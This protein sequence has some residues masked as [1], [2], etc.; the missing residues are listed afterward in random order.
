MIEN[1]FRY[2]LAIDFSCFLLG[3]CLSI[4]L[5]FLYKSCNNERHESMDEIASQI[6]REYSS[7][8]EVRTDYNVEKGVYIKIVN[9]YPSSKEVSLIKNRLE[10]GTYYID[11]NLY[12]K[13]K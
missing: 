8:D 4:I 10:N 3:V 5:V 1:K 2:R 7:Y 12:Y 9:E 11:K 13:K 6:F